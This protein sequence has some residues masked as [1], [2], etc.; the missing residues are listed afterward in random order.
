MSEIVELT[1]ANQQLR[2]WELI[3]AADTVQ[4]NLDG[5]FNQPVSVLVSNDPAYVKDTNSIHPL[6]N[7]DGSALTY[8]AAAGPLR[9]PFGVALFVSFSSAGAWGAGTKCTPRFSSTRDAN[10][11]PYVPPLQTREIPVR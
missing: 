1:G 2:W 10:G 3:G 11:R 9:L 6:T 8:S 4:F 7:E 5:D